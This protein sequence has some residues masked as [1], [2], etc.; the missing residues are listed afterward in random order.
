LDTAYF[1]RSAL[2]NVYSSAFS[3]FAA[4]FTAAEFAQSVVLSD[5][6]GDVPSDGVSVGRFGCRPM[7]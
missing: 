4:G 5:V 7:Y 2:L 6:F 3:A 1:S